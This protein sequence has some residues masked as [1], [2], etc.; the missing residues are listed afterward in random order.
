MDIMRFL[1]GSNDVKYL[2]FTIFLIG[3]INS[4]LIHVLHLG[5]SYLVT[6]LNIIL[7]IFCIIY[8]AKYIQKHK[9]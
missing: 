6:I 8:I 5:N 9:K 4:I 3:I 1:I 2:G 7:V